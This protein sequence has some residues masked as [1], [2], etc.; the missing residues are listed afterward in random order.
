[1]ISRAA[2]FGRGLQYLVKP[3]TLAAT[4]RV[5]LLAMP[6]RDFGAKRRKRQT[7]DEGAATADE[8][9]G[10]SREVAEEATPEPTPEPTPKATPAAASHN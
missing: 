7:E 1:M 8:F 2:F 3:Q 5:N 9:L 6:V 10:E 4:Q